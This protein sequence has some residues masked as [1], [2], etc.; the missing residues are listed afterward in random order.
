MNKEL[1]FS[2][3][4]LTRIAERF[5]F[6]IG[7]VVTLIQNGAGIL[8]HSARE[9]GLRYK[10]L[11]LW[12]CWASKPAVV[13]VRDGTHLMNVVTVYVP[14]LIP[15]DGHDKVL[16]HH[17]SEAYKAAKKLA[18][19]RKKYWPP[20]MQMWIALEHEGEIHRRFFVSQIPADRFYMEFG[21]KADALRSYLDSVMSTS[22]SRAR[23]FDRID[24]PDDHGVR[25]VL[26]HYPVPLTPS[27]YEELVIRET[28]SCDTVL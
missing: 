5:A 22:L 10:S 7:D 24:I 27:V 8:I 12:D 18:E 9:N 23:E 11:L 20:D 28:S 1:V 15:Q 19:Q 13:V 2:E 26:Y 21:S 6:G 25:V 3:H 16:P 14:H 4:A 17:I